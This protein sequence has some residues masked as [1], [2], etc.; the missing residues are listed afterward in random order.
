MIYDWYQIFN[1]PAFLATGLVSKEYEVYLTGLGLKNIIVT[2]GNYVGLVVDDIFLCLD[3]NDKSPFEFDG[4]A[5][6]KDED[7]NVFYGVL[8]D[9]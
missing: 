7:D 9:D 6:Y 1:L 5:I 8:N 2:K 3:M 4:F